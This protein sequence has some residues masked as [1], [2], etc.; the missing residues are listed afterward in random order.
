M[1]NIAAMQ[2][3]RQQ[4]I[5]EIQRR[6]G[7][8]K[9]PGFQQQLLA[10]DAQLRAAKPATPAMI[11]KQANATPGPAQNLPVGTPT[12]DPG[13]SQGQSQAQ[14]PDVVSNGQ[15]YAGGQGAPANPSPS[16]SFSP[17]PIGDAAQSALATANT[18]F[19]DQQSFAAD[20]WNTAKEGT[21]L[22]RIDGSPWAGILSSPPDMDQSKSNSPAWAGIPAWARQ[23]QGQGMQRGEQNNFMQAMQGAA[24]AVGANFNQGPPRG[25]QTQQMPMNPQMGAMYGAQMGAQ[26][27][28]MGMMGGMQRPPMNQGYNQG[29]NPYRTGYNQYAPYQQT[30]VMP[31]TGQFGMPPGQQMPQTGQPP[32]GIQGSPQQQMQGMG[33]YQPFG[34]RWY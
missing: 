25:Y 9:A 32:M 11:A 15:T 18:A 2:A 31:Q 29:F 13:F 26:M 5:N 27:G 28:G 22:E 24:G 34:R 30:G 23:N 20:K 12:A 19:G 1:A 16:A 6:G 4:I 14:R 3:Q 33:G 17:A 7:A 8:T 21:A 10:I